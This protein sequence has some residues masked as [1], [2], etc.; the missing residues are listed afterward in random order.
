MPLLTLSPHGTWLER[1]HQKGELYR[2]IIETAVEGIWVIDTE[3]VTV[4][5]NEQMARI[6]RCRV[7]ELIGAHLL[8]FVDPEN[9]DVCTQHLDQRKQGVREQHEFKFRGKNGEEVWAILSTSPLLDQD[10]R[11]TGALAMVSDITARKLAERLL[12]EA[13]RDLE[14]RVAERTEQL[15]ETNK[16]LEDLAARDPLTGLLN[17]RAF[18]ERLQQEISR[19]RRHDATLSAFILDVDHF[20]QINHAEGHNVGDALLAE[21]AG[22]ITQGVRDSDVVARYGGDEFIVLAPETSRAGALAVAERIR[23]AVALTSD[24]TFPS[25]L[26][27]SIGIAELKRPPDTAE[28]LIARADGALY[29]AKRTGRDRVCGG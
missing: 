10:G 24:R 18:D 14:Q 5:A 13:N 29:Q 3:A 17:R 16:R 19:A 6:L 2:H 9:R 22:I 15:T 21:L 11:Y 28:A 12:Y 1:L 25:K 20:K 4:F 27:F 7:D 8:A 23:R 26:T